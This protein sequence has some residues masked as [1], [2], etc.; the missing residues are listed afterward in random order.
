MLTYSRP[1]RFGRQPANSASAY[2]CGHGKTGSHYWRLRD[3]GG[4][5]VEHLL[6]NTDWR[7]SVIDGLRQ[8][9]EVLSEVRA[10]NSPYSRGMIFIQARSSM[11]EG[12]FGVNGSI[13]SA[14]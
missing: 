7:I 11:I 14:C 13:R 3:L 4:H 5:L 1:A 6:K 10:L 2:S 12:G 8:V 9:G